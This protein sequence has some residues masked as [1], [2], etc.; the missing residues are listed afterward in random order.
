MTPA[1]PPE[2]AVPRNKRRRP[3]AAA[4]AAEATAAS[5][6]SCA[7]PMGRIINTE[8]TLCT[9]STIAS[10]HNVSTVKGFCPKKKKNL[11][12]LP[13]A[14]DP[15][16]LRGNPL[17]PDI[18]AMATAS[19]G[20]TPASRRV[21]R[22]VETR[23]TTASAF[24]PWP[25]RAGEQGAPRPP[26]VTRALVQ[27]VER[28]DPL[29]GPDDPPGP[30]AAGFVAA[31]AEWQSELAQHFRLSPACFWR[32]TRAAATR[33]RRRLQF[34]PKE[35]LDRI[36]RVITEGYTIPFTEYPP[37]FHRANNGPDLAEHRD[38]AWAALSKDMAHGAVTPCN[39]QLHGK[40]RVVS[41]VR[42]APK[43]WRSGKRRFV[44]NMRFINKFIPDAES[45]CD[46]DTL[47]R[48][49]GMFQS[50]GT[51]NN[52]AWGFTMDLASGYHHFRIAEQQLELMGIAVHASELPATAIRWLR[53][54]PSAQGCEDVQAGLFYFT[55]VALPFGLGPSCA[56]FSDVVTALAAAWRRHTV[57]L[58][59]VQLASYVDDFCV[60]AHS[61][62]AAL[63][64][65]VELVYE[66]TAVGLSLGIEKWISSN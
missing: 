13:G 65:A 57:C 6:A 1:G 56:V 53:S 58:K 41:P 40:P 26:M 28:Q 3:S 12:Q 62:R 42:T 31:M 44:I 10:S 47:S 5:A 22:A 43:G 33:I 64:T 48:I 21:K 11:Q 29:H 50:Q 34:L 30:A 61:V 16:W 25:R 60:V 54:H 35:R 18:A 23:D 15:S 2:N 24:V 14:L 39:I 9:I 63:V 59:P 17:H 32:N 51:P 27:E 55:V 37:P 20:G 19:L 4:P 8:G 46:L 7:C 36:M 49:R 45:S 38:E 52:E 66:A